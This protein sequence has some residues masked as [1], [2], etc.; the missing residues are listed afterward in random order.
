MKCLYY[1]RGGYCLWCKRLEQGCFEQKCHSDGK[2]ELTTVELEMLVEGIELTAIKKRKRYD[3]HM[4][5]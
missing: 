5:L 1:D 4:P 2:Y 3:K